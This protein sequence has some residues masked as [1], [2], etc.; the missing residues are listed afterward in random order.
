MSVPLDKDKKA[1]GSGEKDEEKKGKEG[2]DGGRRK[3]AQ[4]QSTEITGNASHAKTV[5]GSVTIYPT[6]FRIAG[7][8]SAILRMARS[9]L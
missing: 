9:E 6:I 7:R 8:V 4:N 5:S 2:K 3:V 1:H